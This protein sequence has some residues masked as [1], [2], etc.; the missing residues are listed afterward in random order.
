MKSKEKS[1]EF[2]DFL[3][4]N[5]QGNLSA[6]KKQIIYNRFSTDQAGIE[7]IVNAL[8]N[9]QYPD[10]PDG[11]NYNEKTD[12]LIIFE[13][14]EFDCSPNN[15]KRKG[16][17]LRKNIAHINDR[18]AQEIGQMRD[19]EYQSVKIIAQSNGSKNEN[20]IT[21]NVGADGD[22]FRDNYIANFKMIFEDHLKNIGTYKANCIN[23]LGKEPKN[24]KV[25]FVFEDVTL[26]GTYYKCDNLFEGGDIFRTPV[27]ITITKQF[28]D[29]FRTAP[30]DYA[31]F[32]MRKEPAMLTICDKTI[33][34][35]YDKADDL[36][37]KEFF[38]LPAMPQITVAKQIIIDD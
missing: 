4:I 6:D 8:W 37:Q 25:C 7:N 15:G 11:F 28:M 13:H 27:N 29:I 2:R 17:M 31:V 24:I 22:K 14:F 36:T 9:C 30:I 26:C 10:C 19:G 3:R 32:S 23:K 12:T 20:T 16:S 35:Y 33:L 1:K 5:C 18:I 38:V 21:Y 34:G